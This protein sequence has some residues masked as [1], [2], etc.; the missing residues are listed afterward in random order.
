MCILPVT[1]RTASGRSLFDRVAVVERCEE[2]G[3]GGGHPYCGP[4]TMVESVR[5]LTVLRK[6]DLGG[7]QMMIGGVVKWRKLPKLAKADW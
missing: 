6:V 2:G 3:H 1:G 7:L 5:P 4:G